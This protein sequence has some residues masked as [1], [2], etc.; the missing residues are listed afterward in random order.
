MT[1]IYRQIH[2]YPVYGEAIVNEGE[3]FLKIEGVTDKEDAS[4]DGWFD[5]TSPITE[6]FYWFLNYDDDPDSF[7][8]QYKLEHAVGTPLNDYYNFDNFCIKAFGEPTSLEHVDAVA[9]TCKK[10]GSLEYWRD[11]VTGEIFSDENGTK[12]IGST[13]VAALGHSWGKVTYT[14]SSGNKKLVAT[15][16]CKNDPSHVQ[17]ATAKVTSAITKE[18]TETKAGRRTYTG[19]FNV[20]WAKTQAKNEPIAA[21]GMPGVLSWARVQGRGWYEYKPSKACAGTTGKS[22]GLQA[23]TLR[24]TGAH[25]TGGIEYRSHV[26]G[27]GWQLGWKRDGLVSGANGSTF[28]RLEA[29]QIRL[30]GQMAKSYDVYYRMHVQGYGWMGWTKNGQK[31]GTQGA[32]KRVEAIQVVLVKKGSKAPGKTYNGVRQTYAKAFVA[33]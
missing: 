18:P 33:K 2:H 10:A 30:Y 6:S 24:V 7:Y 22:L 25:V 31:A 27:T 26:Q 11:F 9:A 12:K 15:R 3:S 21:L 16:A 20:S 8:T 32:S 1:D 17:K 23:F 28:K 5:T 4:K 29:T 13:A 19:T 14:W